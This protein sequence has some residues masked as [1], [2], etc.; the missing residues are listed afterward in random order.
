[1]NNYQRALKQRGAAMVELALVLPILTLLMFGFIEVGRALYQQNMLTK[2]ISTGA[3]FIARAP[4]A[5]SA[6]CQQ[7]ATWQQT[8]DQA[9]ALIIF[10]GTGSRL[11]LRGLDDEAALSFSLRR[12]NAVCVIRIEANIAYVAVA[13][14]IPM[15]N[16]LGL[17][18]AAEERFI[19]D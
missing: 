15:M 1:M 2:A 9:R 11:L 10:P 5:V 18:A 16:R 13:G 3:R 17:N 6:N 4:E 8:V 7:G 14:I 19:G 12:Q